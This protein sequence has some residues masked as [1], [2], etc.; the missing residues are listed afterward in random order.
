MTS[1]LSAYGVTHAAQFQFVGVVDDNGTFPIRMVPFDLARVREEVDQ[2]LALEPDS[3]D[4]EFGDSC[5]EYGYH[6]KQCVDMMEH[7]SQPCIRTQ[8]SM[9]RSRQRKIQML[10]LLTVCARNPS[11]AN[12]I[13]SLEGMVTESCIYEV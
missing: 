4:I 13:R 9:A 8:I 7:R 3:I 6:S 5:D 1:M 11:D 10:D 12:G 2:V